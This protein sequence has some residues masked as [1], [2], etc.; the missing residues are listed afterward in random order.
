MVAGEVA[1]MLVVA[2]RLYKCVYFEPKNRRASVATVNGALA[3]RSSV[4]YVERWKRACA[5]AHL[6]KERETSKHR[7]FTVK[8]LF[9]GSVYWL[10]NIDILLSG[11][12]KEARCPPHIYP[13][14]HTLHS[15]PLAACVHTSTR[16]T[17]P[18]AY[19]TY[20]RA[21]RR[22]LSFFKALCEVSVTRINIFENILIEARG[23]RDI[24]LRII[25]NRD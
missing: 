6:W 5:S 19:N 22:F 20:L 25:R 17:T 9:E 16:A 2:K 3:H 13:F 15:F 23:F 4:V 12:R 10:L 18:R 8:A 14:N 1:P 21:Y 11:L 7:R 24:S